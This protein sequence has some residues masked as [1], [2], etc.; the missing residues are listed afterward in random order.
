MVEDSIT[1]DILSDIRLLTVTVR[2]P[3]QEETNR[4][5]KASEKALARFGEERVE[6]EKI[7]LWGALEGGAGSSGG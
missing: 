5:L 1:A 6:F 2:T 4:I 3:D 7:E